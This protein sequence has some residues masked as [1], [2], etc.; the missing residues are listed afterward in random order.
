MAEFDFV[1]PL[2]VA[3][4]G[5][6]LVPPILVRLTLRIQ[7]NPD[8]VELDLDGLD[9][10][11]AQF[12]RSQTFALIDLGF[13]EPT[14][15]CLPNAV[16]NVKSYMIILNHRANGDMVMTAGLVA[17]NGMNRVQAWYVEFCTHFSGGRIFDTANNSV[18]HAWPPRPDTVRTQLPGVADVAELYRLHRAVIADDCP[19]GRPEVYAPGTAMTYLRDISLHKDYRYQVGRGILYEIPAGDFRLTWYGAFSI[20]WGQIQ[21]VAAIRRLLIRRAESALIRRHPPD[22]NN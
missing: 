20:A 15:L 22:G 14:L 8:H 1:T 18:L 5:Y 10:R 13:A 9:R 2:C 11:L 6:L 16:T 21:P 7:G 17:D 19:E 3:L 12:I 4:A